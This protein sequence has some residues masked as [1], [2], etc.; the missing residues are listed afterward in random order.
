MFLD[1]GFLKCFAGFEL[2]ELGSTDLNGLARARVAPLRGFALR[3][4][5]ASKT[6][7]AH[8]IAVFERTGERRLSSR[9]MV[10]GGPRRRPARMTWAWPS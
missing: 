1:Q 9:F 4:A 3:H 10:G 2:R 5:E 8:L 7:Q 6:W